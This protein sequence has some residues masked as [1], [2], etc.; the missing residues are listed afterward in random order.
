MSDVVR[1][2]GSS[3][4]RENSDILYICLPEIIESPHLQQQGLINSISNQNQQ[5]LHDAYRRHSHALIGWRRQQATA[6]QQP[7]HQNTNPG[8]TKHIPSAVMYGI[9]V[10]YDQ[11]APA[12]AI[13]PGG[14]SKNKNTFAITVLAA[15]VA[16]AQPRNPQAIPTLRKELETAGVTGIHNPSDDDDDDEQRDDDDGDDLSDHD[17]DIRVAR[18]GD[19]LCAVN[20]IDV[21]ALGIRAT[22]FVLRSIQHSTK[23]FTLF[24]C[25]P[26]AVSSVQVESNLVLSKLSI[27]TDARNAQRSSTATL[28]TVATNNNS[29]SNS[30]SSWSKFFSRISGGQS[31]QNPSEAGNGHLGWIDGGADGGGGKGDNSFHGG[32]GRLAFQNELTRLRAMGESFEADLSESLMGSHSSSNECTRVLARRLA[33]LCLQFLEVSDAKDISFTALP[34]FGTFG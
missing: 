14:T 8:S 29:S 2:L 9:G 34:T 19:V 23:G 24:F 4:S 11:H 22:R 10:P 18:R 3:D 28:P 33:L 32:L 27:T 1:T 25:E 6:Q 20:D 12:L 21:R 17:I 13:V 16:V 5:A 31:S 30:G 7:L 26:A 15:D